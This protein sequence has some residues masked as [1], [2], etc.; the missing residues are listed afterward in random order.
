MSLM[1]N[2][3]K[4]LAQAESLATVLQK[5]DKSLDSGSRFG[6]GGGGGNSMA[7]ALATVQSGA[8][9]GGLYGAVAG[10]AQGAASLVPGPGGQA[11]S[12][13]VDVAARFGNVAIESAGTPQ[14]SAARAARLYSSAIRIGGGTTMEQVRNAAFTNLSG[15]GGMQY[16]GQD[17]VMAQQQVNYG[18]DPTGRFG[19][20]T[21]R[22]GGN[23]SALLGLDPEDVQQSALQLSSGAG[24]ANMMRQLGIY[25]SDPATG[26]QLSTTDIIEQIKSRLY[27]GKGPLT[28]KGV[29]DSFYRGGLGASLKGLGL[30][31][32]MQEMVRASLISD[33]GGKPMD[34]TN[35]GMTREQA[36][37]NPDKNPSLAYNRM[38]AND[39]KLIDDNMDT[40]LRSITKAADVTD[41]FTGLMQTLS[42][43]PMKTFVDTVIYI[44]NLGAGLNSSNTG[45]GALRVFGVGDNN[46]SLS[47]GVSSRATGGIGGS[48]S[49]LSL[50]VSS[51]ATSGTGDNNSSLALGAT[52]LGAG[53]AAGSF[54]FGSGDA[55]N[56]NAGGTTTAA[57]AAGD[58][59]AWATP[60]PGA[61]TSGFGMRTIDGQRKHHNGTDIGAR[62]GTP[63]QAIADGVVVTVADTGK[64]SWGKYVKIDHENGYTSLYAHMSQTLVANKQ[65]VKKG[66]VIG[67]VG[68]T[69]ASRGAH[70]HIE[71][72]KDGTHVDPMGVLNGSQTVGDGTA[73]GTAAGTVD[74]ASTGNSL[75]AGM[76]SAT[77]MSGSGLL[78]INQDLTSLVTEQLSTLETFGFRRKDS[79]TGGDNSSISLG[80][81]TG[82]RRSPSTYMPGVRRAKNGDSYVAQDGPVNVHAGEAILNESDAR[83]YRQQQLGLHSGGGG[84]NVTINVTVA[85][86]SE[87]EARKLAS[88]VKEYIEEDAMMSRMG[89]H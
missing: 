61:V 45:R 57:A 59:S 1:D 4:V 6:A 20:E 39:T 44:A 11:L 81:R 88:K 38:A 43:G 83:S 63:I 80:S 65:R 33:A 18:V 82:Q 70:L 37:S 75:K 89:R 84:A 77:K 24:S 40:Y 50:G 72:M 76:P 34:L 60:T 73:G 16:R 26:E 2:L 62:E 71:I 5:I 68:N 66:T 49:S 48:D 3:T 23:A 69:G 17:A 25:T 30:D 86:A 47:L 9:N 79:A 32:N 52:T 58:A 55:S 64:V 27:T 29:N 7:G 51:R 21:M 31:G 15:T 8:Q 53:T 87:S 22:L 46:S 42:D 56:R 85:S 28:E 10:V 67:K 19:K 41:T 36:A 78:P 74:S 54:G 14:D 13:I 12:G 35:T